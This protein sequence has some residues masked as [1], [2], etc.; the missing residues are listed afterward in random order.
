MRVF[1][2]E[3]IRRDSPI[4]AIDFHAEIP[5]TNSRGLELA[6]N[7][8]SSAITDFR[9]PLLVL[10]DRQM[11]GRGRGQNR[12]WAGD[13]SITFSLVVDGSAIRQPTGNWPLISLATG[14]AVAVV[15][16]SYTLPGDV[17]LKWPNDVLFLGRKVSGVLVETSARRSGTFVIGV[18]VNVNNSFLEAPAELQSIG[19]SLYDVLRTRTDPTDFLVGLLQQIFVQLERVSEDRTQWIEDWRKRCHLQG[20]SVQL[21][22]GA[23]AIAGVCQGIDETGA[24]LLHT[25]HG[26]ERCYGG[27]VTRI[28]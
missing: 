6:E 2:L 12:W 28:L 9:T 17:R 25:E 18:G 7:S 26:I 19:I 5:S 24:L 16:E 15:V 14:L 27:V 4:A 3:R 1:D 22:T 8:V 21:S 11:A 13:G 10:T 23:S 20:R